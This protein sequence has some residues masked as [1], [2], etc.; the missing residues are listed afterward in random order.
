MKRLNRPSLSP[1][2]ITGLNRLSKKVATATDPKAMASKIWR[3]KSSLIFDPIR[4]ALG[5]MA[6]GLE[7][8]VYCHDSQGRDIDHFWPKSHFPILA[9]QWSNYFLACPICNSNEKRDEFPLDGSGNPLLIDPATE[10]PLDHMVFSPTT[11][12]FGALTIK[13]EA[14][15]RVFRLNDRPVLTRGRQNAWFKLK[16]MLNSYR[17]SSD[18]AEREK[19]HQAICGEPFQGVFAAMRRWAKDPS[20]LANLD[21][22]LHATFSACPEALGWE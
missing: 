19:Y 5:E 8:C 17:N 7:R 10:E 20:T 9:F 22:E 1:T 16:A 6:P 2:A 4:T 3:S 11:G 13:G 18:S 21:S 14:T 12:Q 15:I